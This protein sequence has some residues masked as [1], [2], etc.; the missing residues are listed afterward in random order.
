MGTLESESELTKEETSSL[1]SDSQPNNKSDAT[2][3]SLKSQWGKWLL[4]L[5]KEIQPI[6]KEIIIFAIYIL[7]DLFILW[8]AGFAFTDIIQAVHFLEWL[9]N[10]IKIA[11]VIVISV[12]FLINCLIEIVKTRKDLTPVVFIKSKQVEQR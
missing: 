2:I 8:L 10:G 11:S 9:Y 12:H 5:S 3:D 4:T 6:L 1:L 7:G